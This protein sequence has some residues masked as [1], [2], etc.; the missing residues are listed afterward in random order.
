[1]GQHDR[2]IAAQEQR[3]EDVRIEWDRTLRALPA[4][5]QRYIMNLVC[6]TSARARKAKEQGRK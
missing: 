4:K 1:M 5:E 6:A 3:L 2:W